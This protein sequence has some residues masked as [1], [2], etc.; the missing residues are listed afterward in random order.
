M[1]DIALTDLSGKPIKLKTLG[2]KFVLVNLFLTDST[3]C[4]PKLKQQEKLL[5]NYDADQLQA[6]GISTNDSP[7]TIEAFKKQHQ[8]SMPVWT[9]NNDQVQTFLNI[10]TLLN[11]N[12]S[13]P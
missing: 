8:L 10:Q 4:G 6:I 9:D 3:T 5:E 1:P 7:K 12:A 13:E 11:R 2:V